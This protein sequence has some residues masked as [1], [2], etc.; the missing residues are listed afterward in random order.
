MHQVGISDNIRHRVLSWSELTKLKQPH[1][2]ELGPKMF[3]EARKGLHNRFSRELEM[4]VAHLA[5]D[6]NAYPN[7][8]FL[9]SPRS[10]KA[11]W[12]GALLFT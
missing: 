11:L 8:A 2:Q 6:A 10:V 12:S 3:E 1:R 5:S 7:L 4:T 9:W